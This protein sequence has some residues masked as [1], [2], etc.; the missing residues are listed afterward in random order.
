M[1]SFWSPSFLTSQEH[2]YQSEISCFLEIPDIRKAFCVLP[3]NSNV[4]FHFAVILSTSQGQGF[5]LLSTH[6]LYSLDEIRERIVGNTVAQKGVTFKFPGPVSPNLHMGT[7]VRVL[8]EL[9]S[10]PSRREHS[11]SVIQIGPLGQSAVVRMVE[12]QDYKEIACI[13]PLSQRDACKY[14]SVMKGAMWELLSKHTLDLCYVS[15]EWDFA[16]CTFYLRSFTTSVTSESPP[17]L[18]RVGPEKQNQ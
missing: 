9:L 17:G 7:Q 4:L 1:N 3:P 10:A 11:A 8:P 12:S 2:Y 5:L 18:V 6:S 16:L 15:K 14:F 13:N